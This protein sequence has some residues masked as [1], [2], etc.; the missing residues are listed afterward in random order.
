VTGVI[1]PPAAGAPGLLLG[2]RYRV[3]GLVGRGGY[4]TVYR[5]LD[6]RLDRT[7]A[8]K[9]FA[10]EAANEADAA[11]VASETRVLASLTHP[12]LVTLFDARLDEHPPYLVMEYIDGP[13]LTARIAEGPVDPRATAE[14]AADL[15]EALRVIHARGIVHRDIKPSNV[16]L[17]PGLLAT[18]PPRA[19]LADFGIAYLMDSARVTATG[20]LIGTAAYLSPEQARGERPAP[21]ADVYALGLVLLEALTGRRA[22][23]QTTPHEAL[24]ARLVRSPDIP[25]T[26][27]RGWRALLTEMMAMDPARRPDAHAVLRA[28]RALAAAPEVDDPADVTLPEI[29]VPG[30][31]RADDLTV[32]LPAV[33]EPPAPPVRSGDGATTA[34]TGP[35]SDSPA[36]RPN[37]SRR[38]LLVAAAILAVVVLAAIA[39]G[40]SLSGGAP[41]PEPSLPALPDPLGGHLRELFEQVS[42]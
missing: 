22:Y 1:D 27:P 21:P 30:S 12:S 13:T 39:L 37:R 15:A 19:T 7:V 25:G 9:I 11:R 36:G 10:A 14:I 8:L 6:E 34:H 40:I 41:A 24:V 31:A 38:W 5:A 3:E 35:G 23:A 2:D 4:A 33:T 32:P 20:T 29:A 42:P 28:A 16:L 26:L 17:R 18:D